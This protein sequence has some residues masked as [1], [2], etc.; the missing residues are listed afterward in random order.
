MLDAMN[1]P[2]PILRGICEFLIS[3]NVIITPA[4]NSLTLS[5]FVCLSACLL[6]CLSPVCLVSALPD[7]PKVDWDPKVAGELILR[8]IT[9]NNINVVG[10]FSSFTILAL[11][12]YLVPSRMGPMG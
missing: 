1:P 6:V 2:A 7:S 4:N 5:L 8:H 12:S 10:L 11:Y 3:R 9:E